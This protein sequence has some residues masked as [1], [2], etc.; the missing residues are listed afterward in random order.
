[1]REPPLQSGDNTV[2]VFMRAPEPG[3]VKT[4]LAPRLPPPAVL[5]LYRCMVADTLH[6][7][8]SIGLEVVLCVHP[9][10]SP[11]TVAAWLGRR[12]AVRPQRGTDL[13][14]RMADAFGQVFAAGRTRALLVG[15]DIPD[16]PAAV[17]REAFSALG[18][19]PAVLGPALDGGYYL[20]G[21]NRWAFLPAAFEGVAWGTN[22]VFEQTRRI[23]A[24]HGITSHCLPP[25]R[26]LDAYEDLA[27]L[28][29][30][31]G[32]AAGLTRAC[33]RRMGVT[34]DAAPCG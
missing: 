10:R 15:T 22:R 31:G 33:L 20:I 28:V 11:A 18:D 14:A 34:R 8:S 17:Y 27:A 9:P 13:G 4:R 25:H 5:A 2:L 1:M 12:Y 16:L 30:G 21:F 3:K 7:L 26:D 24:D 32:A 19:H 23:L 29:C 6:T